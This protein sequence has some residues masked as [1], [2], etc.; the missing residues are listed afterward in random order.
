MTKNESSQITTSADNSSTIKTDLKAPS[1]IIK[2]IS[3]SS[4][5]TIT[6]KPTSIIDIEEL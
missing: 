1:K 4:P 5:I 2:N 6:I 3:M